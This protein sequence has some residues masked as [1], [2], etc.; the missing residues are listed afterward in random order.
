MN[1]FNQWF[2]FIVFLTVI[3]LLQGSDNAHGADKPKKDTPVGVARA[4]ERTS[5][6]TI[7][8]P[9]S[10]IPWAITHIAAEIDGRVVKLHIRDGQRVKAGDLLAQ[11][12]TTPFT[13][14]LKLD[15]A[16]RKLVKARLD[17][18]LAGT[19]KESVD[20]AKYLFQ[21]A[22]ARVELADNDLHRIKKL[23]DDGVVSQGEYDIAK[24]NS[25]EARAKLKEQQSF[26]DELSEGPRIEKI[27]QEKANL[28][29]ADARINITKDDIRRASIYAP[30]DGYIIKKETEVGQWLEKGDPA[31]SMISDNLLKVEI[32]LPQFY[33]SKVDIGASATISLESYQSDKATKTYKASVVEKIPAGNPV[34]RTF[35]V[36][37]KVLNP[38]KDIAVGMLVDVEIYTKDKI[39]KMLYVPKDAVVRTPTEAMVWVVRP[40][41]DKSMT[42]HKVSVQTGQLEGSLVAIKFKG[43]EINNGDLVVVQGNER[44]KPDTQVTII[45][46]FN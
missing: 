33:F 23:A 20:V 2:R 16:E 41:K 36:R 38:D 35:P 3:I 30:F 27:N 29:A 11:M 39:K 42:T 9:G 22:K 34:S 24:A 31:V 12:R 46:Q 10:V 5:T 14:Q 13:L 32:E 28:E 15:K 7:K 45:K 26:L 21:Q 4:V 8:L 25:D 44:L 37:V 40:D 43:N 17:E 6:T 1:D 18:L 19:R